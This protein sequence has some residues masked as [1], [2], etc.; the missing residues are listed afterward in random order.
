[1]IA[2]ISSIIEKWLP[3]KGRANWWNWIKFQ[4]ESRGTRVA[5]DT[6]N[7]RKRVKIRKWTKNDQANLN[8]K[9]RH[10]NTIIKQNRTSGENTEIPFDKNWTCQKDEKMS[11]FAP[12]RIGLK[13]RKQTLIE[14]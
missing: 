11:F 12:H 2:R 7:D 14:T 10:R 1:M 6:K 8:G 13:Y 9:S 4:N 3:Q 5:D